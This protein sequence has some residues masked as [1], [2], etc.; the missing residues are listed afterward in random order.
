MKH[1]FTSFLILVLLAFSS[2]AG[3]QA[4]VLDPT[5]QP[6]VLKASYIG[7][8]QTGVQVLAV[9]P[10]GKILVAG[11]FDFANG[12]LASKIQRLNADGTND[13]T[14]N[15]GGMGANGFISAVLVQP[16][17]RIVIAGGFTVYNG[18]PVSILARLNANGTLD[19]T[20]A[21]V[22]LGETRQLSSLALQPDGKI[23]VGGSNS[24]TPGAAGA[25]VRL[26]ANGTPD[27]SFNIG[28]GVPSGLVNA[29]VV[30]PDGKIV[31]GGSFPSF[32]GQTSRLV[33]LNPNGSLDAAFSPGTGPNNTVSTLALQPDGKIL[34]GG[35]FTTYNGQPAPGVTRLLPNGT[36]DNTFNPGFGPTTATGTASSVLTLR[37]QS[38]GNI[39]VGG[40]FVQFN[41]SATMRVAR[42]F[43]SGAV[44]PNFGLRAGANN[45]V[46]ALAELA[47]GQILV[48][49]GLTQFDGNA[50]TGLARLSAT[51]FDDPT[52]APLFEPR[53]TLA[54]VE[55][56]ANGQLLVRGNFTVFN[57]TPAPGAATDVRRVNAN[58]SLDPSYVVAGTSLLGVQPD[59]AFFQQVAGPTL[60]RILPSGAVDNSFLGQ[61]FLPFTSNIRNVLVQPD[62]RILVFGL[63]GAY[64]GTRN[65]TVRLL[66]NGNPD[67]S[68]T[69]PVG[70]LFRTYFSPYLQ[71]NGKIVVNYS[72]TS[73][74]VTTTQTVRLNADGTPDAT[75]SFGTGP[76]AGSTIFNLVQQPNGE[77]LARGSFTTFDGQAT[78]FG[79]VRLN[80]NGG[81]IS[82]LPGLADFYGGLLVQPDGRILAVIAS[83]ATTALVRLNSD[84][85]RDNSFAPVV[86]PGAIFIGDDVLTATVLQPADN[87]II[88]YGSFRSVAGQ[89]RIGLARLTNSIA[90]SI[91]AAAAA[92]PLEVYPNPT[93]QHLTVAVP[94]A[95]TA[96]QATLLDLTGRAVR[97]WTLP[98]RQAEAQLDLGAVAAGV[99]VLRIPTAAG[100]YQQKVAVTR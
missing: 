10:D 19:A 66:P 4:Q 34:A 97:T 69:P 21:Q 55:P 92:L 95:A 100:T 73:G 64:S 30:Q 44:D 32:N 8:L 20:F 81:L 26:N 46:V 63:F 86:I 7:G 91:R 36:L 5:F 79:I 62:G 80:A 67:A 37:L 71:T 89:P 76:N 13:G 78:P 47:S 68:F 74:T 54:Q 38:N 90:S 48:G 14:F 84:G 42:L 72:E 87:K 75:F 50:K 58:G 94:V 77:F 70:S 31:V 12:V 43:P 6:T 3:L 28:A 27:A 53:G 59:G 22:P 33:R 15:P 49:G 40:N 88:V 65:G 85:S 93:R 83:G 57:G 1:Q 25:L 52:F 45:F 18:T 61:P 16:D 56:L 2:L 99:Y 51:G 98:A 35:F 17:G 41:G 96:L 60:R 82:T 29:I 9:Q 11:G 23:L 39:L 24:F